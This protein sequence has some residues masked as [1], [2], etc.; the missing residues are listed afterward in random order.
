M[1]MAVRCWGVKT[2]VPVAYGMAGG[3]SSIYD[4]DVINDLRLVYYG[5]LLVTGFSDTALTLNSM[6]QSIDSFDFD[7][8]SIV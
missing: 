5:Y 1:R 7:V 6:N 3:I 8:R 4:V 2:D